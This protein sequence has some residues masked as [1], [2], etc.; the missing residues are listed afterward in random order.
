MFKARF[1]NVN[2]L[3]PDNGEAFL[4]EYFKQQ[5]LREAEPGWKAHVAGGK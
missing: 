5:K 2:E 1:P 3:S 4:E